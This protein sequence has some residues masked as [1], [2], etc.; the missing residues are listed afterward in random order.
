[1]AT[2]RYKRDVSHLRDK[3][4][5]ELDFGVRNGGH[6]ARRVHPYLIHVRVEFANNFNISIDRFK[7]GLPPLVL[8]ISKI[9]SEG[10]LQGQ[11]P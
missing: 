3:L 8:K 4:R 11:L 5:S 7:Q 2:L 10:V 9:K 1:M 6:K